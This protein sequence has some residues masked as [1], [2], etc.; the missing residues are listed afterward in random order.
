METLLIN[1]GVVT[2][3]LNDCCTVSF[4]PT[5][6][7]FAQR[8]FEAFSILDKKQQDYRAADEQL[9]EGADVFRLAMERDGEMREIING[10][11]GQDICTPLFGPVNVYAL[12]DGLPLWANLMLAVIDKMDEAITK[13]RTSTNPRIEKYTKKY[14]K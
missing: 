6:S 8:L 11:F 12:A 5:D 10:V 1:T 7:A 13:E 2:Y 4:N 14:H 3:N 9:S